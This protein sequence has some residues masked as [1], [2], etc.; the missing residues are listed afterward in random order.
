MSFNKSYFNRAPFNRTGLDNVQWASGEAW[1]TVD[2]FAGV[3]QQ[4]FLLCIP[5]ENVITDMHGTAF[6]DF[7][8]NGHEVIGWNIGLEGI[9][10]SDVQCNE[11]IYTESRWSIERYIKA[12]GSE[13]VTHESSITHYLHIKLAGSEQIDNKLTWYI[14]HFMYPEG[15]E[16]ISQVADVIYLDEKSCVL[17]LTLYPGEKIVIDSSNYNVYYTGNSDSMTVINRL[18]LDNQSGEQYIQYY[19]T[20]KI[21]P[22][23]KEGEKELLNDLASGITRDSN[24][25]YAH[26][27]KW[28]DDLNRDATSITITAAEGEA[29]LTGSILYT[30]RYL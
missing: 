26:S 8:A 22:L 4:I 18:L 23:T 15:N 10:W 28:L 25:I 12:S 7:T 6:K 19:K 20:G 3:S 21:Y 17:N 11:K 9:F 24:A 30:E 13:V 2:A 16:H 27:G 14:Q 5:H 29:G 1:E